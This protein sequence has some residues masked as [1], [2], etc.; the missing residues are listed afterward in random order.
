MWYLQPWVQ[1]FCIPDEPCE[2]A[3]R[4]KA[5]QVQR[6]WCRVH[7]IGRVGA[8]CQIPPH[9]WETSQVPGVWLCQRGT[10]QA[11]APSTITYRWVVYRIRCCRCM[12]KESNHTSRTMVLKDSKLLKVEYCGYWVMQ[13]YT[14]PSV[15]FRLG[16]SSY[17][18]TRTNAGFMLTDNF[19][20][21]PVK[22]SMYGEKNKSWVRHTS[23]YNSY[24]CL[25]SS[26]EMHIHSHTQNTERM[27]V[28]W[29]VFFF[30]FSTHRREQGSC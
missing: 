30:F 14:W 10:Q 15:V 18:L 16:M 12:F 9:F 1:N 5:S 6:V 20:C 22:I 28:A 17:Q 21:L 7:H 24:S 11:E 23:C 2:H 25:T 19:Q 29:C 3:H 4:H 26:Q 27:H 8:P 13:N